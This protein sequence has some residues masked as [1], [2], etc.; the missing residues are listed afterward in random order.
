MKPQAPAVQVKVACARAGQAVLQRDAIDRAL[1]QLPLDLRVAVTLRD[2]EG[3]DYQE[4]AD[5]LGISE[6]TGFVHLHRARRTLA[7]RL[8]EV[9]LDAAR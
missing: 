8:G 3:L 1:G 6:S 4:I 2:V 5:V 9:V 7:T